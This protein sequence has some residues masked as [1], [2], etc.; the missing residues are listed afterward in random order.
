MRWRGRWP[1]VLHFSRGGL[2]CR[3]VTA[4]VVVVMGGGGTVSVWAAEAPVDFNREVRPILSDRCFVCHGTD[5]ATRKG[6]LRLD[7]RAAALGVL[8]P[9]KTGHSEV[10]DRIFSDDVDDVMPPPES[11]LSLSADEKE[12]LRRWIAEGAEYQGH[13]A[14]Q[15]VVAPVVP[16]ASGLPGP[17]RNE[18]DVLVAERLQKEALSLQPMAAPA[19]LLRRLSF[20]LTGLPPGLAE[21]DAFG[22]AM[23]APAADPAAVV[24]ATV[25]RLL[26]SPHFGERMASDWLD[27][28]RFA[29]TFGYQSD[30]TMQVWPW[31][32]W[33]I[34]SFNENLPFDQFITW[35]LAGDLLPGATRD[36]QLATAFNRLHRQT[37]E[38]G[39]V[40][41]EF[42][43]QYVEDRVETYGMAFLGLTVGCAK[44]HDHKYDPMTQ[45]DYYS[46][47]SY[48]Q[49]VDESG[50]YSHFT[51]A[52]P[53]PA[54]SLG[55]VEQERER[56]LAAARVVRAEA[57]LALQRPLR[58]GVFAER[59][60]VG[61]AAAGDGAWPDEIGRFALDEIK[62]G[63]VL[64]AVNEAEPGQ[65]FDEVAVIPGRHGQ[66]LQFSG[67]N[68]ISLSLGGKWTRDDAFSVSLWINPPAVM[69]RAVVFH[70]SKA[71]TDAA[72]NGYELLIEDG[73]LSAALIHF[74]P[75]N[76]LRVVTRDRLAV[77]EWTHVAWSYDGSSRAA[78]LRLFVNGVEA[79][80][81]VVRDA[82]TKDINRGGEDRLTFGQ[83][84][85]DRGFKGGAIDDVRLFGRALS[86]LEAAALSGVG[87]LTPGGA[88]PGPLVSQDDEFEY[89]LL[90]VDRPYRDA[91]AGLRDLRRARSASGDGL[92]EIMTMRELP[93]PKPAFVLARG[94][95]DAPTD[96]V[97]ARTP[98]FLP[99][100]TGAAPANRLGLARWTVARENPL[101][102]RVLVN[103]LWQSFFGVGLVR[104]PE[105]F[106]VQGALPSH[107]ELLDFL[108][109]RFM[110]SGWDFKA[111]VRLMVTSRT[112]LQD[113]TVGGDVRSRDPDNHLLSRGPSFR[114]SAEQIRDQALRAAGRL[115]PAVGGPSVDP[116]QANRRSLYTFWKRTMP[117]V[118]MD[119]FDMAKREVC[120]ARRPLT[121]TPLQA[122]TLLNEPTFA[123]WAR[124][125]AEQAEAAHA[126]DGEAI[127]TIFRTLTSHR[128]TARQLQIL[129][130]LLAEQAAGS[131]LEPAAARRHGLQ[132]VAQ[133]AMNFDESVMKR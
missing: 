88:G 11:N 8:L 94:A 124:L 36:Q 10:V 16:E 77:N 96:P 6:D 126:D 85:R 102:A 2:A 34:R 63:R 109:A 57:E 53:T 91:L 55:T 115:D 118:R 80:V 120:S 61:L 43:V 108:A 110:D 117:D 90:A 24:A 17:Q 81:E 51:D 59:E 89:F 1:G 74:W 130:E 98:E 49:N 131:S 29:D 56:A 67:E 84:F 93:S 7:D 104:T 123:G 12:V 69:E 100:L 82:L 31:R 132:A 92:P 25:D 35:Q 48:F 68:N 15:P 42:R 116:D 14:F 62:D 28:A 19:R 113:S 30:A 86:R 45:R 40:N 13:W 87:S 52:T 106:G 103:R 20:D 27:V 3:L 122:L 95:Y 133:A 111:L 32:D 54:L 37:N 97:S 18:I 70:R 50:L 101:T 5:A 60:R 76:A 128:P 47:F 79:A 22:E 107:P 65:V 26:A 127:I 99:P 64:N 78:G 72:S 4:G 41:E 75:G 46:L 66:A 112:Y 9:G 23:T 33:V 44:C 21:L 83:R 119:I 114:L 39:S 105:D 73:R 58:R 129:R 125:V 38:G 121:Q 71:W